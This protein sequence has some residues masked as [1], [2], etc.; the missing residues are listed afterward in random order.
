MKRDHRD[1]TISNLRKKNKALAS[2]IVELRDRITGM[3]AR[4]INRVSERQHQLTRFHELVSS[5]VFLYAMEDLP[6]PAFL[7]DMLV[8]ER[9]GMLD[10]PEAIKHLEAI[11]GAHDDLM[12]VVNS[13]GRARHRHL[14]TISKELLLGA[15]VLGEIDPESLWCS[16]DDAAGEAVNVAL[17]KYLTPFREK[18]NE[19]NQR[20]LESLEQYN[21]S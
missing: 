7:K 11:T 3:L 21:P 18:I 20:V 4:K 12:I 15:E 1:R 6:L 13:E 10:F 8:R 16:V 14:N 2:V 5:V 19:Q 9:L 17:D